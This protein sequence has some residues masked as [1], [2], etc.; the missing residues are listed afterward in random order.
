MQEIKF[1]KLDTRAV[2]PTK[3]TAGA[4]GY[5]LTAISREYDSNLGIYIY[6]TGLGFEIPEGW[7]GYIYPRS[8]IAKMGMRLT[9]CVGII[10]SDYRGPVMFKFD[11]KRPGTP[12]EIGDKIGQIIFRKEDATK[13]VE[14]DELSETDRGSGGFGSTGR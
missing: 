3:G 4:A 1:K 9:N 11:E 7:T 14:T 13:L 5:D 6:D 8:S 10:D 2:T 12:Y